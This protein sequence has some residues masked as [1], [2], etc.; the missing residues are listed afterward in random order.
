MSVF[1]VAII[2]AGAAGIAAARRLGAAGK[3]VIVLEARERAGGRAVVD[4]SLGAPA[5]LGAAWLHFARINAWTALAETSR[6][7]VLKRDPG[8]GVAA[9]IGD[10]APTPAEREAAG[11]SY[12]RYH[13]LIAAAA[14]AGRDVAVADVIPQDRYRARF[15]AIMTWAVGAESSEVSTVDLHR[16]ADSNDNW[17]VREGMGAVVAAA[18][19]ELPITFGAQVKAID[20][21]HD[22]VRVDSTHGRIEAAAVIVTVPTTVLARG[23]IRFTPALP[24]TFDEAFA[25]LP[26]GDVNKVFFRIDSGRFATDVTRQFLGSD[27]TSRTC[28]WQIK[29]A[30]QPLLMAFFGGNLSR[31]LEARG[32]LIHFARDELRRMFGAAVLDELGAALATGW[33]RDPYSLGSYSAARPGYAHCREQLAL[34]VSP[35]LHFAG[36]ACSVEYYGTLHGAWL[37]GIAAAERLL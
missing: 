35:R 7:T 27:S 9:S 12:L 28:S 3:R 15:D 22:L 31:E 13:E 8:W 17:A 2:G 29:A 36:E 1:D 6:F 26:L 21:T 16:Y 34:P 24:A 10:R 5:D 30:D 25:N 19:R 14:E 33:G 37:S 11:A 18:A 4:Q 23:A 20:W 32:E